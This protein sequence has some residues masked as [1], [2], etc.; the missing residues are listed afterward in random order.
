MHA[1]HWYLIAAALC[2][3]GALTSWLTKL[4]LLAG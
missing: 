1:G 4:V 3:A 2:G